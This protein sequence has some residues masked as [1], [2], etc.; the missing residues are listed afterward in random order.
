MKKMNGYAEAFPNYERTP[1]AVCA[2]LAFSLAMRL[3]E[4]DEVR[5]GELLEE[6]WRILHQSGIVSQKPQRRERKN[7]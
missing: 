6:E 7:V 2:A 4:E 1:K 3:E 5:V